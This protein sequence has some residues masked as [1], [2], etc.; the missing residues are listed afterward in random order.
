MEHK[1]SCSLEDR[2]TWQALLFIPQQN[3]YGSLWALPYLQALGGS[4]LTEL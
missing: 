1:V 2:V 3:G 4:V